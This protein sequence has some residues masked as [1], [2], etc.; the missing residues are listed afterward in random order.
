MGTATQISADEYLHT[1]FDP[2]VDFVDGV[3]EERNLGEYTHGRL[4]GLIF[5]YLLGQQKTTG[6]RV[7]VEQRMQVKPN[8]FRVPDVVVTDGK[9]QEAVLTQPPLLCIEILSPDDRLPRILVR[10]Q[11][12][13]IMG[14][15]EVWV[16]NPEPLLTF[17]YTSDGLH[18]VRERELITADGR[19]RLDLDAIEQDLRD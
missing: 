6:T 5:A 2:D 18:E 12:Y 11:E 4:Q 3:L 1:T 16:I 9:P 13:V 10:A 14:V 8:R 7:V 19:V 15:P 17:K